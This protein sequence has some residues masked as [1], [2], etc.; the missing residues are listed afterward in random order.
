MCEW[1]KSFTKSSI[2]FV[3]VVYAEMA[4]PPPVQMAPLQCGMGTAPPHHVLMV[5]KQ[6]LA[7][8]EA[9]LPGWGEGVGAGGWKRSVVMELPQYG[10]ETG[11]HLLAWMGAGLG[12]HRRSADMVNRKELLIE[13]KL[14]GGNSYITYFIMKHILRGV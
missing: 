10:M 2:F 11:T 14:F 3:K 8:M 13:C 4:A 9:L 1:W 7:L 5:G 6:E 12:A